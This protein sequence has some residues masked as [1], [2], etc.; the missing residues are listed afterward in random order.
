MDREELRGARHCILHMLEVGTEHST[1][2]D[3]M[4]QHWTSRVKYEYPL[5]FKSSLLLGSSCHATAEANLTRNQEVVGSI[6]GLI[7]WVNDLTLP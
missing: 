1:G 4:K 7:L 5:L 3:H 2:L 6:P